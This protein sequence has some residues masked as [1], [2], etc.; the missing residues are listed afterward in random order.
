MKIAFF[1]IEA[2]EKTLL[3]KAFPKDTLSFSTHPLTIKNARRYQNTEVLSTFIHCTLN[4]ELLDQLPKLKFIT[5]RST[6][7]DHVDVEE[8]KRRKI[9]VTNVPSYGEH[10]VAEHTFALLLALT[11]KVYQSVD[12]TKQGDFHQ[13]TL[14]GVDLHQKT[15]GII[16]A[17]NIGRNVIRIAQGFGMKVLVSDP[18]LT[19][20]AAKKVGATL[21]PLNSLLKKADI[22]SLHAPHN[23]H[24]HHLLNKKNL[25]LCK[26][27]TLLINTARG[28]LIDTS[29]LIWALK[30]KIIAGAALDVLENECDLLEEPQLLK[31]HF[32]KT[33]DK[34]GEQ[35]LKENHQ[36][37]HMDNVIIT[38]HNAFNTHEALRRILNTD[39][40]SIKQFKQGKRL[41][42]K[43]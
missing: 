22:I 23:S 34:D 14:R 43:V 26:P 40:A 30:K 38:P 36:L 10:T 20:T 33:C 8:C 19:K 35:I 6:G 31:K 29:G 12:R 7:Y 17:G 37:L 1:E 27:G 32:Q 9:K 3:R 41:G 18:R 16:G 42:N 4:K 28:P 15:I 39:I 24:T 11:R 5:T 2:W 21:L 13:D 25:A